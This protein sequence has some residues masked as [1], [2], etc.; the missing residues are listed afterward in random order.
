VTNPLTRTQ[1]NVRNSYSEVWRYREL[2]YFLAWRDVKVRYKQTILGVLWA[3]IQPVFT[4]V[5]FTVLFGRLGK[6][7]SDGSPH[8]IFYLTALLP[9]IYF[10]TTLPAAA[11]S[12]LSNTALL[13]KVYFPRVILP[14]ATTI[15][16]IFD[17]LIGT[18]IL[19]GMLA[20]YGVRPSVTLLLWPLCVFLLVMFTLSVGMIL[21]ALNI[22]YR[23]VKH[24]VPF[25]IQLWLFVTPVIYP[26]SMIPDKY[27][28]LVALNP[29]SGIVEGF[30]ST[31]LPSRPVDWALLGASAATT[32]VVFIA[33]CLYFA[34]TEKAFADVI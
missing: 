29:L 9:W 32:A 16:G 24:A 33:A 23:D 25:A 10:S 8:P 12:L 31:L 22:K 21:S 30:R 3:V 34:S 27:R 18:V 15:G 2:L 13:T 19:G 26:A 11:S 1:A 28:F 5:V 20:Y 17:F 7:P 6:I 14:A 4:M